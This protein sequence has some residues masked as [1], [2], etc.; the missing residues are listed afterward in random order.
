MLTAVRRGLSRLFAPIPADGPTGPRPEQ[1][2]TLRFL[3]RELADR[4]GPRASIAF[5]D[6]LAA[7]FDGDGPAAAILPDGSVAAVGI[8]PFLPLS[9]V[10]ADRV[11]DLRP[12]PER[13]W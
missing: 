12:D 4:P 9:A 3:A 10:P 1:Y 2:A 5:H 7:T 11:V 13:R 8:Y 6:A